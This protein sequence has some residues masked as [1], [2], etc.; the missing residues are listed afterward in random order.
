M[1]KYSQKFV[2]LAAVNLF[3]CLTT[4]FFSPMEVYM[5][6][7]SE[8]NFPIR[9]VW[10]IMLLFAAGIALI[11]AAV[12]AMLPGKAVL[13]LSAVTAA[14]GICFYVQMLFLNGRMMEMMGE[15]VPFGRKTEIGNLAVWAGI[16]IC[17]LL[18]S[19][20]LKQ[21]AGEGK[22][23]E[24][25]MILSAAL[26]VIQASGYISARMSLP[27]EA[28]NKDLYLSTEGE[29]ELSS[30][31]NVLYFILD[32]CDREYVEASL[33]ADPEL[34]AEYTGF[35]SYRNA[36]SKYSRTYPALPF[37]LTGEKCY[38]DIPDSE[39]IHQ[40][41]ENGTFLPDL[42][43]AGTDIRLYTSL[44]YIDRD[45]YNMVDNVD[46]YNSSALGNLSA[47]SLIKAMIRLGGYREMPYLLKPIFYYTPD[48]INRNVL[49]A[50]PED[51][52]TLTNND[53]E[54]YERLQQKQVT[55][56]ESYPSAFRLY[57]LFGPHPG[58]YM[59]EKAEYDPDASQ[60]D[61][62]R[63]DFLIL[64][65]YIRYLKEKGLY[66]N[67][68]II[69]TADH[70]NQNE[71]EDFVLHSPPCIVMLFKPI[72]A[73]STKPMEISDAPV[74]HDDLFA[75]VLDQLGL[76]SSAWPSA[77]YTHEEGEERERIYYYTAQRSWGDGEVALREYSIR[78][79]AADLSNWVL[80]GNDWDIIYS[81]N[82]VSKERLPRS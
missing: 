8:F 18:L 17:F 65:R 15:N 12:E 55:V 48:P 39:Y 33:E 73:D 69:I 58:C 47:G 7:L 45:S 5:Q 68:A 75:T 3:F 49:K 46:T 59:N 19:L 9:H 26:I 40:A 60:T 34:F 74:S 44:N 79:D 43:D 31:K 20:L 72:G 37:L 11:T 38:F 54:F 4:L 61:A 42:D 28:V 66:D 29:F 81:A 57:H 78:G 80:T 56:N 21:R 10:W 1:K 27:E 51:Y 53:F 52:F 82:A 35:T 32:T 24:V 76:D 62:A 36:T 77:L 70:G 64:S 16:F 63:G 50:F 6:N 23:R 2:A 25:L 22:L 30:Q 13:P 41:Y 67:T 14:L 71:A